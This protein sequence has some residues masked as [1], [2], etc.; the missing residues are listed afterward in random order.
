MNKLPV[1]VAIASGVL[2]ASTLAHADTPKWQQFCERAAADASE[3]MPDLNGRLKQLGD[4]G[5]ELT[6]NSG[7]VACFKRAFGKG[8][9]AVAIVPPPALVKVAALPQAPPRVALVPVA[10]P[11][12]KAEPV[13]R[14]EEV[15]QEP[16]IAAA[17]AEV[18]AAPSVTQA[19]APK[20]SQ[21]QTEPPSRS[22]LQDA[23]EQNGQSHPRRA[24]VP[25]S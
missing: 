7:G 4:Q 21:A 17:A 2:F 13:V 15:A 14:P 24:L 6:G 3:T 1:F 16:A 19:P 8:I 9:P 12:A 5:W 18:M 11:V 20:P 23:G 25:K 10:K 22:L